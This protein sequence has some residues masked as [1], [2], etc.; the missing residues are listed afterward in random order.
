MVGTPGRL[1]QLMQNMVGMFG[2]MQQSNAQAGH[3]HRRRTRGASTSSA[4]LRGSGG[5]GMAQVVELPAQ[6]D[7]ELG[8]DAGAEDL[9]EDRN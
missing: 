9:G 2:Q 8:V 3:I 6:G 1:G 5:R 4:W 7:L